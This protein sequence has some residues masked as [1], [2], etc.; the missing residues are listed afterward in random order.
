MALTP[1]VAAP[2]NTQDVTSELLS[3]MAALSGVLTDYNRGSQIR[4]LSESIGAVAEQ[5]S[6]WTSSIAFQALM[7]SAMSVLGVTPYPAFPSVG[8]V[9]FATAPTTPFNISQNVAISSGTVVQT[10][11]GVQFV[12]TSS[13][14]LVSGTSSVSV[15]VQAVIGGSA[16]N[17]PPAAITQI[18]TGIMYPLYVTNAAAMTGG[19]PA[20]QLSQTLARA[21]AAIAAIG[22]SSPV[23]LA[24]AAIG[25]VNTGT[26]EI[27]RY[28]TCYEPWIA[29][30]SGAGSGTAGFTIIIDNGLGTASSGL[31]SN[32][33]YTLYGNPASGQVGYRPAGV[34]NNVIAVSGT[35]AVVGVTGTIG[36]LTTTGTVSGLIA[37]A[38]SGYFSLA[39]GASAEQAVLAQSVGNSVLGLMTS[40]TV[41]LYASGGGSAVSSLSVASSGRIK[42]GALSMTLTTG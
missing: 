41:S 7:Y 20:E 27:V 21:S 1:T 36:A 35:S 5:Q 40:L 30:G 32:V 25:V 17:V 38:V 2:P 24:N 29:A 26:N 28:S 10:I 18:V 8:T 6:I 19:T 34:P 14:T 3:M 11:G 23:A 37:A 42:L 12:T 33:V 22:L 15:A 31:I 4:T 9:T 39:F 13:A 16:G